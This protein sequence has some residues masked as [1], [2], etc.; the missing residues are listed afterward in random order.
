MRDRTPVLIGIL[1]YIYNTISC[2][3][4]FSFKYRITKLFRRRMF[5]RIKYLPGRECVQL[6]L[7]LF[8]KHLPPPDLF[9][10]SFIS[11]IR[12]FNCNVRMNLLTSLCLCI[13]LAY[14]AA[15]MSFFLF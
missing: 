8:Q 11:F 2:F 15:L 5:I 12:Q 1:H 10:L 3:T 4:C 7:S 14:Y 9:S 13:L 6:L